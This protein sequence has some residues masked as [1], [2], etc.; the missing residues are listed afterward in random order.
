M[1][2]GHGGGTLKYTKREQL[3]AQKTDRVKSRLGLSLGSD[4]AS[5]DLFNPDLSSKAFLFLCT[6]MVRLS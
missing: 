5:L 3:P 4:A 2:Q 1:P 6:P